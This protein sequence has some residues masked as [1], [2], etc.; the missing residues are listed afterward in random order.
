[1]RSAGSPYRHNH[2]RTHVL[3]TPCRQ[4]MSGL[5]TR[6]C[7]CL[8]PAL[9]R[10]RCMDGQQLVTLGPLS[11]PP[12]AVEPTIR[13]YDGD[14]LE[15]SHLVRHGCANAPIAA[16]RPAHRGVFGRCPAKPPPAAREC[17]NVETRCTFAYFRNVTCRR[18]LDG[19]LPPLCPIA[20][21]VVKGLQLDVAQA[22]QWPAPGR[23][24][25]RP[26]TQRADTEAVWETFLRFCDST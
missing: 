8:T 13:P 16:R 11:G 12:I 21:R 23:H 7:G 2:C 15:Y 26:C 10:S 18:R 5:S 19:G 22:A 4:V 3:P 20:R 25:H 9:W 17:Q 24:T 1:M 14:H 6:R